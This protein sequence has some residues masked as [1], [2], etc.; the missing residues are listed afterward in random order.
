V[1][2]KLCLYK[3][4]KYKEYIMKIFKKCI[5]SMLVISV[6]MS[7]SRVF[8][9]EI[10]LL[11][12]QVDNM[13]NFI[14]NKY[15]NNNWSISLQDENIEEVKTDIRTITTHLDTIKDS[16]SIGKHL[17]RTFAEAN[18]SALSVL[19]FEE[20]SFGENI[21]ELVEKLSDLKKEIEN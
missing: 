4:C 13:Y 2:V 5:M 21:I 10:G 19:S 16:T 3:A 20:E 8:S 11:S 14:S 6:L 7:N 18:A 1:K 9:S 17:Y 12:G 15:C